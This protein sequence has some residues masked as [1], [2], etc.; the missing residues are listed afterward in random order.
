MGS[1]AVNLFELKSKCVSAF[2]PSK[3]PTGMSEMKF[4]DSFLET[5]WGGGG[6]LALR[7]DIKE[8]VIM[9]ACVH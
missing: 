3:N 4:S 2:N 8:C 5:W 1:T 6:E 7:T 9:F